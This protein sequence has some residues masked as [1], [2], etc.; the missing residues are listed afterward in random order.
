MALSADVLTT[1]YGP[2]FSEIEYPIGYGSAGQTLYRGSF[3][4][5]SG[6]TTVTAGYLKNMATPAANDIVVG[7]VSDYGPSCGLANVGPG[8]GPTTAN[9]SAT[10]NVRQGTFLVPVGGTAGDA[11]TIT[12]LQKSVYLVN[13]TAVGGTSASSSRPVAGLLVAIPATD[14]TIPT[15]MCAVDVGTNNGPW[16]G[17]GGT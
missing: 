9:G 1:S 4:A 13:E 14:A 12:N 11:L 3:T 7:I 15:G 17:F 5:V 10:A 6:G 16:G 8:L 2:A